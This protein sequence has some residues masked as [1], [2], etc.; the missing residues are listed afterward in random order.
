LLTEVTLLAAAG[1]A[2]GLVLARVGAGALLAAAPEEVR[3]LADTRLNAPL[4]VFATLASLVTALLCGAIPAWQAF[5]NDPA[6]DL[7]ESVRTSTG[8]WRAARLRQTLV[9]VE[10]A[11][12]TALLATAALLLHSLVN[13]MQA[14]RGYQVERVLAADLSLSGAR[15]ALP[16]SRASFYETLVQHVEAL[17]GVVA[18]GAI[19][20]LPAV[21]ASS[22]ASRTIFIPRTRT[23][24]TRFSTVRSR[25]FVA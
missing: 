24:A 20:D 7:Q 14:D 19:S 23:S 11:L 22:G 4:F 16:N 3:L 9:G 5:R 21:A 13:V 2:L 25:W 8:G 6:A 17:P 15:Y 1:G 18:A 12:A 10:M